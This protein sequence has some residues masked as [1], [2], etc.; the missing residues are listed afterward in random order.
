MCDACEN[1][2]LSPDTLEEVAGGGE[3]VPIKAKTGG[4]WFHAASEREYRNGAWR[5]R[6]NQFS[7]SALIAEDFSWTTCKCHKTS[8]CLDSWHYEAGCPS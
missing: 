5:K 2:E 6:C 4:C 3:A 1:N 7:C 8:K